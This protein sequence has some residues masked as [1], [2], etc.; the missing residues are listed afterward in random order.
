MV[1]GDKGFTLIEV[2]I[3]VAL[4]LIIM[5]A[6]SQ[7]LFSGLASWQHGEEQIDVVQNMRIT[8]DRMTREIRGASTITEIDASGKFIKMEIPLRDFTGKIPVWYKYDADGQEVERKEENGSFQPIS[9]RIKDMII[10]YEEPVIYITLI[11]VRSDG[12]EIVMNA[13]VTIR[14]LSR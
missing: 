7:L 3:S 4:L 5:T 10:T 14:S 13:K 6:A 12:H 8:L 9:S 11:G 1:I 2:I